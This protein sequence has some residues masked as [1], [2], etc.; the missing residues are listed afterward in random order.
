M[1]IGI[2]REDKSKWEARVPL[3]PAHVKLLK[4]KYGIQTYVQPSKIR[5]FSD[6]EYE[7]FGAILQEDLSQ[8]DFVF[9]VKEMPLVF[10][11]PKSSY[12]FFS[13]V[14]KGQDYNMPMLQKLLD[15]KCNLMDY[16]RIVDEQDRRL[17]FFGRFA[18]I[19]GMIDTLWAYGEKLK[20]EGIENH[21]S[22]IKKAYQYESV[23]HC[24]EEMLKIGH[25]ISEEGF[26]EDL[27]PLVCGISGYGHV[28]LGAQEILKCFPYIEIEPEQLIHLKKDGVYSL[29]HLYV[30]V[31][32][33]EDMATP[34]D[35]KNKFAL[36]D[37][38]DNPEKYESQ[39]AQYLPHLSML[40]N[41]IYW[42]P[43]YPRLVTKSNLLKMFQKNPSQKLKAIGDITCDHDGSIEMTSRITE[44]DKPGYLYD[45]FEQ[46]ETA[47]FSQNGVVIIARDNL[48][49]EIPLDS[50][51][52][53]SHVLIEF[54]R[55]LREAF[56]NNK[57]IPELLPDPLKKALIVFNGQLTEN[58]QYLKKFL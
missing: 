50:S 32:D 34:V 18:G 29:K 36:K 31:F 56:Q 27:G 42:T 26:S 14:I 48:P 45:P 28:S 46:T 54:I 40:V 52:A 1:N 33:E 38:Y 7:A 20:C 9:G 3:I 6:A 30:V 43:A 19:A 17:I 12:M 24:K 8:C 15:L 37:Y 39:F 51:V 57:L 55:Q 35:I 13:H 23:E 41:S 16:E 47:D 21:F 11:T 22:Q 4:E 58:Y 2:R 44:P 53:F 49:C 10:F 5:I 25:L